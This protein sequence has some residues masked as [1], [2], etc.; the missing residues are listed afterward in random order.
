MVGNLGAATEILLAGNVGMT[1]IPFHLPTCTFLSFYLLI[2][3]HTSYPISRDP[4]F[5]EDIL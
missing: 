3:V 2:G 5:F 4:N 1:D